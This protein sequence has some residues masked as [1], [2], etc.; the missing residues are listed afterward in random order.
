MDNITEFMAFLH[1]EA[2]VDNDKLLELYS[3]NFIVEFKGHKVAIPF[4]AV[5][6]NAITK[7]LWDIKNEL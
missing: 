7:A 3:H 4:D 1:S 2:N 5:S 6:F